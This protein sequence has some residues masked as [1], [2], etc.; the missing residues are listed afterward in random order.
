[1]DESWKKLSLLHVINETEEVWDM[2]NLINLG[3]SWNKIFSENE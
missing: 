1:V 2:V 3:K